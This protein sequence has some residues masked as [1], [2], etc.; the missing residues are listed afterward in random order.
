MVRVYLYKER[1][2]S[3]SLILYTYA[4]PQKRA[5][6]HIFVP[7]IINLNDGNRQKDL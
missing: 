3:N 6:L 1:N 7:L 4:H 2:L 5:Q